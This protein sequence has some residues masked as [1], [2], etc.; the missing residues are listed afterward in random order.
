MR[1]TP[2]NLLAARKAAGLSRSKAAEDLRVD[3]KTL[4]RYENG[5]QCPNVYVAIR[6]SE[7]YH[8]T[9]KELFPPRGGI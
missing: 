7:Y 9:V 6:L 8:R 4:Y 5:T 3:P 1:E 2:N